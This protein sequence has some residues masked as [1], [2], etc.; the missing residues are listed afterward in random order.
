MTT[1]DTIT[2]IAGVEITGPGG[3][4]YADILTEQAQAFLARL[5]RSFE[6]RRQELL[7]RRIERQQQ[8]D[9]G[10]L[11]DFLP[12][13]AE[14]RAADWRIASF[15]EEIAD[16]RVEITGPVDRKMIINALNS[17]ACV[18]MADFE[19]SHSP[20][21]QN[22]VAGQLNLLDAVAGRIEYSSPEGKAYRLKDR[23]A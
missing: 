7:Q 1:S 2:T 8:F 13:T 17:G 5:A 4:G 21:W 19:D 9:A 20:T 11:P 15:P 16:R 22:T 12:E 3:E 6:A 14:V 18:Y 10:V 23:V